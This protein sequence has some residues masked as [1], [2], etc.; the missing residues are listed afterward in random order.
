MILK[1]DLI[2]LASALKSTHPAL[3]PLKITGD[4][5]D[6]VYVTALAVW[7]ET[8]TAVANV[9]SASN[10]NFNRDRFLDASGFYAGSK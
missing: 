5:A 2:K 10:P 9:C 8:V 4:V 6:L 3:M 1:G 7:K